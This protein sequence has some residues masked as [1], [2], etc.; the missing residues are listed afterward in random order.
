M[1]HSNLLLGI[2]IRDRSHDYRI[3]V[4][5]V[6]QTYEV[7]RIINEKTD[8]SDNG[9]SIGGTRFICSCVFAPALDIYSREGHKT[10]FL[11]GRNDLSA[12]GIIVNSI[13]IPR[14]KVFVV[15]QF[16]RKVRCLCRIVNERED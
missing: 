14:D 7:N 8:Y 6:R 16:K 15:T 2:G 9:I 11:R 4:S 3:D 13:V 5:S 12:N 1:S 10:C